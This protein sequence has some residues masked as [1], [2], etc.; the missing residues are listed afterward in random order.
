VKPLSCTRKIENAF[1]ALRRI[2]RD[3]VEIERLFRFRLDYCTGNIALQ[4]LS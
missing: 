3:R 4:L 1:R 2:G